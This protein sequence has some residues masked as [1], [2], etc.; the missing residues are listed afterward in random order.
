MVFLKGCIH[1]LPNILKSIRS[2]VKSMNIKKIS[3]LCIVALTIL[4]LTIPAISVTPT[5]VAQNITGGNITG[6]IG[7]SQSEVE[8]QCSLSP[9]CIT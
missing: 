7:S 6:Q 2:L 8:A 9:A 1:K 4:V 5:V 3:S